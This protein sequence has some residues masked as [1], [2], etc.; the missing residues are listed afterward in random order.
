[1]GHFLRDFTVLT[2]H[3]L[4]NR[5][6]QIVEWTSSFGTES[7]HT[8]HLTLI[9]LDVEATVD[10]G[11]RPTLETTWADGPGLPAGVNFIFFDDSSS[12]SSHKSTTPVTRGGSLTY[13]STK[14]TSSSDRLGRGIALAPSSI[15]ITL[16]I[17]PNGKK[18]RICYT[19]EIAIFHFQ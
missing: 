12:S 7:K 5:C 6:P 13:S 4:Q 11:S 8:G 18:N 3:I 1:M 9:P 19:T 10:V 2:K 16:S 15:K 14:I 17:I